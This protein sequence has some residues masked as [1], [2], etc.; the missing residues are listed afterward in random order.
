M[1]KG[2][3]GVVELGE[4]GLDTVVNTGENVGNTIVDKGTDVGNT[5][6]NGIGNVIGI[7]LRKKRSITLSR[8]KRATLDCGALKKVEL[9]FS[10]KDA[11]KG[12]K[13]KFAGDI[14]GIKNKVT[15]I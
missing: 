3:D 11:L 9:P 6:K 2:L 14:K 4:K 15:R 12:L 13:P 10:V 1:C 8:K 7:D 5:V